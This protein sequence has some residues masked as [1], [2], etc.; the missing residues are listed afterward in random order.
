MPVTGPIRADRQ[1][2]IAISNFE[3]SVVLNILCIKEYNGLHPEQIL[4]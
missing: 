2:L 1:E 4:W 3:K